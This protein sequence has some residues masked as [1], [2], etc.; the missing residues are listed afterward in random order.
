MKVLVTGVNGQL[1]N[2]VIL[3]LNERGIACKGVDLLD[4]DITDKAQTSAYISDYHPSVV[5]HCAAYTAVDRAEE[6]K[7]LC[8]RVNAVGPANIAAACKGIDAAMV[9]SL[10]HI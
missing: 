3:C 4:F 2:D 7:D 1:G 9:L 8:Y 6:E 10:I 5:I